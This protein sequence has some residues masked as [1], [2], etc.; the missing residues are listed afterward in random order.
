[1]LERIAASL[2]SLAPAEQ[3]VAQLVLDDPA[4]FARL[5]VRT[6][7]ELARVSKPT[8]VRFCRSMGYDGLADLKLKLVGSV[9]EGVPFVHRS[10]DVDDKAGDVLVKVVD[11]SVAAFLEYRNAAAPKALEAAAR[12]FCKLGV[13]TSALCFLGRAIR[14]WWPMMRSTNSSAWG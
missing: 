4:A 3:R 5:P 11:N 13:S 1:M 6:L 2:P 10:V 9:S 8:V 7:A 12:R 14:A